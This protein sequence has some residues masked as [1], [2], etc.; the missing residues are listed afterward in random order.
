MEEALRLAE[1]EQKKEA[2][3]GEDIVTETVDI[4]SQAEHP[5]D[6]RDIRTQAIDPKNAGNIRTQAVAD[7]IRMYIEEHYREDLALQDVAGYMGYADAYFCKIFKQCFD[8]NFTAYLTEFRVEKAK[9]LLADVTIQI[10]D[11]CMQVGFR[12]SNYFAR[13]FKRNTG[14]TP[15]EYRAFMLEQS[16]PKREEP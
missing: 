4:R 16:L 10:R 6:R 2:G 9:R 1:E 14:R 7:T 5:E 3:T 8:Q 13:V 15:S 12:D 11:I